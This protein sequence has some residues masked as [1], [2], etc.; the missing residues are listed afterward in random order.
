MKDERLRDSALVRRAIQKTAIRAL[1]EEGTD[2]SLLATYGVECDAYD[3]IEPLSE[4]LMGLVQG[5]FEMI[6]SDDA[7]DPDWVVGRLTHEFVGVFITGIAIGLQ[8]DYE[9]GN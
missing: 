9:R 3:V 1:S 4:V 7:D 2:L 8:V 5:T 6:D